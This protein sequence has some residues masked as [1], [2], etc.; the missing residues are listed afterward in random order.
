MKSKAEASVF[1]KTVN[2]ERYG[3]SSQRVWREINCRAKCRPDV[4]WELRIFACS[5]VLHS[6]F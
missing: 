1:A 6:A 4:T 5:T 3:M 2:Q